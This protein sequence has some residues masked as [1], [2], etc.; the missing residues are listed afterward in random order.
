MLYLRATAVWLLILLLAILNGGF[1]ESVLSPQFG[2]P[3]AQF[4]SG[5]LLIGCV[6]ALSYL[7]VPRLGAQS[8]RQLMGIGVFWLALT[9][10]F[11]F[12]FGLLVQG[13][14]WQELVVAYTFHN[15]NMWPIV[16]LVTLLAPFLGGRRSLPRS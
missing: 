6:L 11:E 16:L 13:K 15:G 2:D 14:S 5:M 1:R 3:S 7:L 9:L 12:G 4:I 8:Q 10:M